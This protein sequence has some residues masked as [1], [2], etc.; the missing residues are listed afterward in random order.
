MRIGTNPRK[1]DK[2]N[3]VDFLHQ[4]IIPV[5]I[6]NNDNYFKDSFRILQLCLNSLFKTVH[7]KTFISVVN[8]GSDEKTVDY[9]NELYAKKAIQ[10]LIHTS[11]I[12]KNN[13]VL[14]ALKGHYFD[15]ITIADADV[16][17]LNGWQDE[18]MKVFNVFSKAGVVGIVPQIKSFSYLCSNVLFDNFFS[19]RMRFTKV[20]NPE[21]ME[22]FYKSIGW[23][24]DYNKDYLQYQLTI[25]D[26]SCFKAVIG[27]GHFVATYKNTVVEQNLNLKI[28]EF[29]SSKFD[30]LMFDVPVIKKGGWR[31]TTEDNY[32]YHMGNVYEEWMQES[33]ENL[34]DESE[35]AIPEYS[36]Y[37]FKTS[38]FSYYT[39]NHFFRRFLKNKMIFRRFLLKKGLSKEM[40]DRY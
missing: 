18:T 22:H 7:S 31:L 36:Y 27:S 24:N 5:Y 9:L 34:K 13:A 17:F 12:G 30:R 33:L 28:D 6:P 23:K 29:V 21:G 37:I 32:A 3:A 8:N 4:I 15:Y 39:K 16:F 20:V 14:K 1:N 25:S 38:K 10:E 26:G 2:H 35:R 19:S 40:A 11:N